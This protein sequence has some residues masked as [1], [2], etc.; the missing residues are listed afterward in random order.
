MRPLLARL[1][2]HLQ[3]RCVCWYFDWLIVTGHLVLYSSYLTYVGHQVRIFGGIRWR[4][5]VVGSFYLLML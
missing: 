4:G 3:C 1:G 5:P 2:T